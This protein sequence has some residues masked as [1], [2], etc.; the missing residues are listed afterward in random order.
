MS[1]TLQVF[2]K[3][4][5]GVT[6]IKAIDNNDNIQTF[7]KPEGTLVIP[8]PG[9]FNV[10]NYA[11]VS[12]EVDMWTEETIST[13]GAVSQTLNPY[14]IYHFTGALTSL[15][16]TLGQTTGIACY[17]FDFDCGSTAPTVSIPNT[18]T[19]PDGQ[20]FNANTHY[21]INILNN[22]GAVQSWVS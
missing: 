5:S 12:V 13:S 21:E 15:T 10:T 14:V 17:H 16:I 22:Y 8:E 11:F 1:E 4:Y 19:M 2:G 20:T 3:T 6:S 9:T 18:V 7:I